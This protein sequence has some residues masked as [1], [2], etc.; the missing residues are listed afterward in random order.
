MMQ[1]YWKAIGVSFLIFFLLGTPA[2]AWDECSDIAKEGSAIARPE[3]TCTAD[4]ASKLDPGGK[5]IQGLLQCRDAAGTLLEE[6]RFNN[7]VKE[8]VW[9]YDLQGRKLTFAFDP[10]EKFHKTARAFDHQGKLLCELSFVHGKADGPVREYYPDGKVHRSYTVA[11]EQREGKY[12]EY[13]ENGGLL[14]ERD[15][16]SGQEMVEKYYYPDGKLQELTVRKP[17]GKAFT[18]K[19][20]WPG[21]KLQ[22]EAS[23]EVKIKPD[24]TVSE[25]TRVGKA[26]KYAADGSLLEEALYDDIGRLDG[27][28]IQMDEQGKRT[29][30]LYSAGKLKAK[31][32]FAANGRQELAEEYADDGSPKKILPF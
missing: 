17:D 10:Q 30:S 4:R 9:F 16:V 19:S 29:E 11:G 14:L 25:A 5:I 23:F 27:L 32:V 8:S 20:Y 26:Y 1:A 15:Y 31:K 22:G 2:F 6:T 13:N 7:G 18:T 24:C 21:G 28:Q 3:S 12:L